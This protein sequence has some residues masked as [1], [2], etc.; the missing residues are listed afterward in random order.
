[1]SVSDSDVVAP[2]VA[3]R[4]AVERSD[5][6]QVRGTEPLCFGPFDGA[7]S[8]STWESAVPRAGRGCRSAG[9]PAS[10]NEAVAVG[11]HRA[12]SNSSDIG[13]IGD[14]VG[15]PGTNRLRGRDH[16]VVEQYDLGDVRFVR[17]ASKPGAHVIVE[18]QPLGRV[19]HETD[20]TAA[21]ALSRSR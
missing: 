3:E 20:A 12:G 6:W 17:P 16:V 10:V 21:M 2:R 11:E 7:G 9:S 15:R 1:M 4:A 18:P 19:G 8:E 5:V 14:R 13:V